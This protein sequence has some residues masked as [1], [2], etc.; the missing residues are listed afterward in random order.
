MSLYI[1]NSLQRTTWYN[2][3]F[4]FTG[5]AGLSARVKG[6][7]NW[8]SA[9][10]TLHAKHW[11]R[12]TYARIEAALSTASQASPCTQM[13]FANFPCRA[14]SHARIKR[15]YCGDYCIYVPCSTAWISLTFNIYILYTLAHWLRL[16]L[17]AHYPDR[18]KS[19]ASAVMFV[20][21]HVYT[22]KCARQIYLFIRT[23]SK[24]MRAANN[25]ALREIY[26]K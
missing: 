17:L 2:A 13:R 25:A 14:S 3:F 9:L 21:M 22:W 26:C 7:S 6:N 24:H 1:Y 12:S 18:N 10:C 16:L 19:T 8:C 11:E 23:A 20:G 15:V 4:Y 5:G